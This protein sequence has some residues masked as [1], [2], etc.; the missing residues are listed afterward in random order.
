MIK[1]AKQMNVLLNKNG[2]HNLEPA[3]KRQIS[4]EV[5]LVFLSVRIPLPQI[6]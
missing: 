6:L 3:F 5:L 1:I 4:I 2:Y